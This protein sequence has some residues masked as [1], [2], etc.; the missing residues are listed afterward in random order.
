[1][2]DYPQAIVPVNHVE[3]VPRRIRAVLGNRVIIDTTG[4]V[5][6][7]EQPNYPQYYIP[8]ADIEASFLVDEQ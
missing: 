7:W 4:A 8:L 5:Y 3:P 2:S 6:V 1:M